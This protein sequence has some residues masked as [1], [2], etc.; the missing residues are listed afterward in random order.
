MTGKNPLALPASLTGRIWFF[1]EYS[2]ETLLRYGFCTSSRVVFTPLSIRTLSGPLRQRGTSPW[3]IPRPLSLE[4]IVWGVDLGR[5]SAPMEVPSPAVAARVQVSFPLR[6]LPRKTL[7]NRKLLLLLSPYPFIAFCIVHAIVSRAAGR[8]DKRLQEN[9]LD[10]QITARGSFAA[11]PACF[12]VT[13]AAVVMGPFADA[14]AF[15]AIG[16]NRRHPWGNRVTLGDRVAA[17]EGTPRT[18]ENGDP[19]KVAGAVHRVGKTTT[20]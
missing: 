16:L 7:S 14:N 12:T 11:D 1:V 6:D 13:V 19:W 15:R 4:Q 2:Q 10:P 20:A 18:S 9:E 8:D 3:T 17:S 5:L